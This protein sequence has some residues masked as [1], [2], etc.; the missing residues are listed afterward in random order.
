MH[1]E[2]RKVHTGKIEDRFS[3]STVSSKLGDRKRLVGVNITMCEGMRAGNNGC[4]FT[5][6]IK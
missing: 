2:Y 3:S 4:L 1:S 5:K 6:Y